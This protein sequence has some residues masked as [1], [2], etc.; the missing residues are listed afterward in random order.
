MSFLD[1]FRRKNKASSLP[2]QEARTP[3]M[4]AKPAS[5]V[6]SVRL[7]SIEDFARRASKSSSSL[8]MQMSAVSELVDSL[9]TALR[10]QYPNL[11]NG[12]A[13]SH[14]KAGLSVSCRVCGELGHDAVSI[15]Y[16]AGSDM[17]GSVSFG[18]AN[19]AALWRGRRPR[20]GGIATVALHLLSPA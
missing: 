6:R 17:F 12:E 18:G 10:E 1:W 2:T 16:I 15:L 13:F 9:T 4:P 3:N 20:G 14:A 19:F 5:S 7:P 11:E 8:V